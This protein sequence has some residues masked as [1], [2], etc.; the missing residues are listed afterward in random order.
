MWETT[1]DFLEDLIL[2]HGLFKVISG[3][4][5]F[6]GALLALGFV[7]NEET[8]VRLAGGFLILVL[9]L[10]CVA[11]SVDRR[12]LRRNVSELD[13]VLERYGDELVAKQN[14]KSFHVREWLE[15]QSI[16]QNG[17][18]T[19]VRWFV[20]VVGDQPLQ[21][22]WHKAEMTTRRDDLKYRKKFSIEAR[23]FDANRAVGV[24]MP[25]TLTWDKHSVNAFIHLDRVYHSGEEVR[26]RLEY[27]WP[28]F[29]RELIDRKSVDPTEWVFHRD[30]EKL[31]VTMLFDKKLGIRNNFAITLRPQTP[32]P[33]QTAS[34]DG[35]HKIEFEFLDPPKEVLVG[36]SLERRT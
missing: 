32:Q 21:T 17:H 18:T 33:T 22:F 20:L 28:E 4:A 7:V 12:R 26:V 29:T 11:L 27:Y 10:T 31:Q 16:G 30:V 25:T 2:R 23:S 9:L 5:A 35:S 1:T 15:E 36:F 24:R 13:E 19:I 14:S 8:L 34:A 3:L 6:A